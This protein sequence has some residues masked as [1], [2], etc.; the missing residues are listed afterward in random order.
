[1]IDTPQSVQAFI[2]KLNKLIKKALTIASK[3][4][5]FTL[6][7]LLLAAL[8]LLVETYSFKITEIVCIGSLAITA[9]IWFFV[10]LP[11]SVIGALASLFLLS[12]KQLDKDRIKVASKPLLRTFLLVA[13]TAVATYFVYYGHPLNPERIFWL[14]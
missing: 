6:A 1:M 8:S 14:R 12:K 11:T 13:A 7:V 2:S 4:L 9:L 3:L 5:L 10:V